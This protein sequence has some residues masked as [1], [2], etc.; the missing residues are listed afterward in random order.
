L[1]DPAID[2]AVGAIMT[3]M[4]SGVTTAMNRFNA[5]DEKERTK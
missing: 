1:I 3:W 4:E 5:S 2:R